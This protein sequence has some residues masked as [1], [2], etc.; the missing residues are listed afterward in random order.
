M[1]N[2]WRAL[3]TALLL[4]IT[5]VPFPGFSNPATPETESLAQMVTIRRDLYGIPHIWA[6]TEGAAAFGFGYAQAEDH[7]VTI[8]RALVSGR[9]EE[10]RVFGTGV[11]S[12]LVLRLY[13]NRPTPNPSAFH[14]I[15]K[16]RQPLLPVYP[17]RC[18]L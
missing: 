13:D 14:G 2:G 10:G 9:G 5:Q 4:M 16:S 3:A 7:C 15:R 18:W 6:E 8:A 12:D 1:K 17:T 11:E